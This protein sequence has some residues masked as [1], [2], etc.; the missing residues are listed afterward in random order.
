MLAEQQGQGAL[1]AEHALAIS[2]QPGKLPQMG[3]KLA[4]L[5]REQ[6]IGAALGVA[7]LF[8]LWRMR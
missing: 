5:E 7:V 2:Q 6:A 4:G 3:V 8:V 1:A